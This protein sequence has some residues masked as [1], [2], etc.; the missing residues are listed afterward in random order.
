M[1]VQANSEMSCQML[2]LTEVCKKAFENMSMKINNPPKFFGFQQ[3]ASFLH[4]GK[5]PYMSCHD[6]ADMFSTDMYYCV[7]QP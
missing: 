4:V 6:I 7:E 5:S 3:V 2:P 1:T